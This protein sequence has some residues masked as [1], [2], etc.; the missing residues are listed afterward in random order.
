MTKR[1]SLSSTEWLRGPR[2]IIIHLKPAPNC[3]LVLQHF[4]NPE[5]FLL[6]TVAI[7]AQFWTG[8][9]GLAITEAWGVFN[10][11]IISTNFTLANVLRKV[12]IFWHSRARYSLKNKCLQEIPSPLQYPSHYDWEKPLTWRPA[13]I[14]RSAVVIY[15][16]QVFVLLEEEPPWKNASLCF[17]LS[18]T[19]LLDMLPV[20]IVPSEVINSSRS[21]RAWLPDH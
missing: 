14:H 21:I 17:V 8:R 18:M 19:I 20:S 15:T 3:W 16:V 12:L 10:F 11:W 4:T 6:R 9:G 7:W 13:Y 5:K 1:T 2:M